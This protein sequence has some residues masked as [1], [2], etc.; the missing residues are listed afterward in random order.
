MDR[1]AAGIIV[2]AVVACGGPTEPEPRKEIGIISF[3]HDPV[4][5]NVPDAVEAAVPF[6]VSVRTYGGGCQTQG[7]TDVEVTG[8][9]VD[10]RPYDIHSGHD[11]CTQPLRM[12]DHVAM[13]TIH[14]HGQALISFHGKAEPGDSAVV[15]V[16][17]VEVE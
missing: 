17:E 8:H 15:F 4:V 2:M 3:F 13:V 12:F 6:E 16:R 5:I 1:I 11:F 14:E 7:V 10:V 9:R